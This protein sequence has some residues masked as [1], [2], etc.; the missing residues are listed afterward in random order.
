MNFQGTFELHAKMMNSKC[1]TLASRLCRSQLSPTLSQLFNHLLYI[2]SVIYPLP[3]TSLTNPELH[4]VQSNM[5]ACSLNKLGYNRHY[6]HA[7]AFAP[8]NVFGCGLLDLWIE[9]GL[10]H[11]QALL[12]HVGSNHKVGRDMLNSLWH[13]QT[14]AGV[15]FDLL[16][17]RT[18]VLSYLTECWLVALKRFC[19]AHDIAITCLHNKM[20]SLARVHDSCLMEQAMALSFKR[21]E[22]VDVNLVGT[23]LQVTTPLSNIVS[24]DG[25]FILQSIWNAQ[26]FSDRRSKIKFARQLQPSYQR[27]LW[28]RLL[29]SYVVRPT[30]VPHLRLKRYLEFGLQN[31]I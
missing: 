2:P 29:R 28:R 24:A 4:K 18:V 9:Q 31:L 30:T 25:H 11:I 3:V 5:P 10:T 22:L 20:P 26:Q 19:A 13:L 23:Y 1:D 21:Q 15:A 7:V 17:R 8:H 6:P 16:Q 12:D 14:E 27:G